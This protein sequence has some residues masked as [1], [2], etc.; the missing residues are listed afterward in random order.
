MGLKFGCTIGKGGGEWQREVVQWCSGADE[1]VGCCVC[2]CE[3]GEEVWAKKSKPSRHSS[4]LGAPCKIAK[5]DGVKVWW[6]GVYEV[7]AVVGL[8]AHKMQGREGVWGK[9]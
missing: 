9:I 6:S 7:A 4:V 5:G 2:K 3:A 1:M 8:C